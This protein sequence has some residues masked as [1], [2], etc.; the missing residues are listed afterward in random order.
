MTKRSL[1]INLPAAADIFSTQEDRDAE[2]NGAIVEVPIEAIS[3]FPDHPYRV[4]DDDA[5]VELVE[6][7]RESGIIEPLLLMEEEEGG[8]TLVSGHR[9][10]RAAELLGL[11]AVPAYVRNFSEEEAII[12]MVD[13]NLQ[14]PTILPSEKALAIKMKMDALKRKAGRPKGNGAP[15]AHDLRGR[16]SID[17]IAEQLGESR[18]QIRRYAR[19]ALL[20]PE[21]LKLVDEGRMKMR[22][23]VE[24]SYLTPEE[25]KRAYDVMSAE[26]C[27][28]SHEQAR[29]MRRMSEE[30]SVT[31][32]ALIDLMQRPKPNQVEM[33]RF[34]ASR[35]AGLVPE[36]ATREDIEERLIKGLE[37]LCRLEQAKAAKDV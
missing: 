33:F 16:K 31:D 11:D 7:I 14:R 30:G 4:V 1:E 25:Q 34:P 18:D 9:R 12:A 17:V 6:S 26:A 21:L 27:T 37:L 28:P 32:S 35:L 8:Y 20:I 5:M 10:K 24:I 22:P 29:V 15:V 2:R 19:I 13:A 23:A 36:G 3:P